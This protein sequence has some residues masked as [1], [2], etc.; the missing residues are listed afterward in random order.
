M[1]GIVTVWVGAII[2]TIFHPIRGGAGPAAA[3]RRA[4]VKTIIRNGRRVTVAVAIAVTTRFG[5]QFAAAEV[6]EFLVVLVLVYVIALYAQSST[7]VADCVRFVT[8]RVAVRET[9]SFASP[10]ATVSNGLG[11]IR[12]RVVQRLSILPPI[13]AR[14]N[15]INHLHIV[16]IPGTGTT[17]DY[18]LN[19][20]FLQ[21]ILVGKLGSGEF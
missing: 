14:L 16:K 18:I 15:V 20:V 8:V 5:G 4:V 19:T 3:R 1:R 17:A 6:E 2:P 9:V 12:K 10:Q 13:P 21:F 7:I 11:P